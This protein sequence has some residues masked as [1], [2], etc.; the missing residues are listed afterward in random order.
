[1]RPHIEMI[2]E[3]DYI[4]HPAEL[5]HIS[6]EAVQRNLSVD[7]EDGSAA[8]S[9]LFRDDTHRPS[10]YHVADTEWFVLEG[11]MTAGVTELTAGGYI[12]IPR[13]TTTPPL[14]I[15]AE[16][17]ALV[18]R[19]GGDWS[20][21][22]A[23]EETRYY[24]PSE[25][26]I[27]GTETMAWTPVESPEAPP[28]H[29]IKNLHRNPDTGFFTCIIWAKPGWREDRMMHHPVFEE[30]YTISGRMTYN[31][32]LFTPGTY[33]FRPPYIKHGPFQ[34]EEPDGCTWLIRSNGPMENWYTISSDVKV[35][36]TPHNYDPEIQGPV[37]TGSPV[38]SHS[39]G[40]WSG[41]GR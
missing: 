20:F 30:A 38:R 6:G 36:E 27:L 23:N 5:P 3:S 10:G 17:R 1:M 32:G 24:T 8:T 2:H 16:T 14:R 12:H 31:F 11:S 33:M 26:T 37:I 19:E 39:S 22:L 40:P 4:W 34:S 13:G 9:V 7:E 29:M 28:G 15:S 18:Y 25:V 41:E 21:E 35:N